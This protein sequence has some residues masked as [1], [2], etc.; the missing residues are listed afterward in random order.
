MFIRFVGKGPDHVERTVECSDYSVRLSPS[1]REKYIR[2]IDGECSQEF[3]L[4]QGEDSWN[5]AFLMNQN[6]ETIDTI[7]A[8]PLEAFGK[9]SE[10]EPEGE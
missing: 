10:I 2:I 7:L 6:G 5:R 1:S 3:V 9:A 8:P 4:E